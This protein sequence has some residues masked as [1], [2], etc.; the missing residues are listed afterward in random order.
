MM[1]T[2]PLEP[3][4]RPASVPA[5]TSATNPA[6]AEEATHRRQRAFDP[7]EAAWVEAARGG[8]PS[9]F[10]SLVRANG[11]LV[12]RV[13]GRLVSDPDDRDDLVQETFLR[14]YQALPN[15]RPGAEFRPWLLTIAINLAR[16]AL[17]RRRRRPAASPLADEE[18]HAIPLPSGEPGPD[19]L[20]E[21]R[22][23]SGR[24]EAAFRRLDADAQAI[25]WLRVREGLSYQE[26]AGVLGI[27][28]GT[29][30][31]RLSRAREALKQELGET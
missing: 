3:M 9:A 15:F 12:Y 27:A 7:R 11:D 28:C 26:I 20:L 22:D 4:P 6:I 8:E 14:A 13:I 23:L 10:D 5:S 24:A 30:M 19:A 2:E 25:L 17:R 18:G 16:D 21:A 29:V 31:S 1:G